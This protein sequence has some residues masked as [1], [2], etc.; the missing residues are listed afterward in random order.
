MVSEISCMMRPNPY[1]SEVLWNNFAP[2]I[3][4]NWT[5]WIFWLSTWAFYPSVLLDSLALDLVLSSDLKYWFRYRANQGPSFAFLA[6]KTK[7]R[8]QS[9]LFC[10]ILN[11]VNGQYFIMRDFHL[12]LAWNFP[13]NF[14]LEQLTPIATQF[15]FIILF[16][17]QNGLLNRLFCPNIV[18]IFT[19]LT[20][21]LQFRQKKLSF[22]K[23]LF[24]S[25]STFTRN[26]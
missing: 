8:L 12:F 15:F 22:F 5:N 3:K 4:I 21:L 20:F 13:L 23:V 11:H 7:L 2:Y 26:L 9:L 14:S 19:V 6:F 16:S 1:L 25:F 18:Q 10:P 24:L 17:N